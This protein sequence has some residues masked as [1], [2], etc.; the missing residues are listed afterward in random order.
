MQGAIAFET[1][2]SASQTK[3]SNENATF[4]LYPDHDTATN[5]VEQ[6][7][8][9]YAVTFDGQANGVPAGAPVKLLDTTVG[10]V[11]DSKVEYDAASGKL[12][13]Q[14][15][16]VIAADKLHLVHANEQA[17]SRTAMDA[18]MTQLVG[19]GLR[20]ELSRSA[21]MVGATLVQLRFEPG[22][23]EATL[24]AGSPPAI[25]TGSG[26]DIQAIIAKAGDVM[27]KV[28]Q[29]PLDQIAQDVHQV[30]QRMAKLS[31]SPELTQSLQNL[32]RSLDNVQAVTADA[33]KQVRPILDDVRQAAVEAQ[34]AVHA[35]QGVMGGN[36]NAN[37][38]QSAALP[39]TL[40]ELTR[41]ARSLRELADY[42][43][44]H[45]EALIA[46]RSGSE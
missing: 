39:G 14:A 40:Y 2:A 1:P 43:D 6:G 9:T 35:A 29:L 31:T 18:M 25:P 10:A 42:L 11:R 30:T 12:R 46:G 16:L 23:P 21:P 4:R 36:A 8:V 13:T 27:S 7:G 33:R 26:G 28:D 15:T 44:R 41:A 32:D 19:Q 24:I 3:P 22:A 45:P 37:A 5:A 38:A 17:G 20:A 34:H